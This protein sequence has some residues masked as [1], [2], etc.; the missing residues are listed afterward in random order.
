MSKRV[1]GTSVLQTQACS[2]CE[3]VG[4]VGVC[5]QERVDGVGVL[6]VWLC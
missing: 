1:G 4:I 3:R 2:S 6:N 5:I